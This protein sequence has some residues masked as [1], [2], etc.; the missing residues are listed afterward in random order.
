[1]TTLHAELDP[2]PIESRRFVDA[3]CGP[4]EM[5]CLKCGLLMLPWLECVT[6]RG[7]MGVAQFVCWRCYRG[8]EV[9]WG[10]R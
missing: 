10:P 6:V 4:S 9:S 7:N 2:V 1:M 5:T 3:D 8:A